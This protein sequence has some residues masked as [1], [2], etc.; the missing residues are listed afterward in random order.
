[1][2]ESEDLRTICVHTDWDLPLVNQLKDIAIIYYDWGWFEGDWERLEALAAEILH[3]MGDERTHSRELRRR[4][5]NT[6]TE[7]QKY[8][9]DDDGEA[10]RNAQQALVDELLE[11]HADPEAYAIVQAI[12]EDHGDNAWF[13]CFMTDVEALGID[14]GIKA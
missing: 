10:L 13:L 14:H 6:V 2:I 4:Y 11:Y 8:D 3:T 9:F 12:D 5:N 1:L 7:R